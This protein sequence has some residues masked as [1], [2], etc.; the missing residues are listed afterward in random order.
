MYCVV[1][2][3]ARVAVNATKYFLEERNF[4]FSCIW[5]RTNDEGPSNQAF[6]GPDL[7]SLGG[8]RLP[9]KIYIGICILTVYFSR[10]GTVLQSRNLY[11]QKGNDTIRFTFMREFD[12]LVKPIKNL[13]DMIDL[14]VANEGESIINISEL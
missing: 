6:E 3:T 14:S 13:D 12:T 5:T 11:V 7:P 2:H 9:V 4:S 8:K 10:E 1:H